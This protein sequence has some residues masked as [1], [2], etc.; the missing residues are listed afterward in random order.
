MM[1]KVNQS[2]E[3]LTVEKRK[4]NPLLDKIKEWQ[5]KAR[6]EEDPFNEY[7]SFFIAYNIFSNAAT[8]GISLAKFETSSSIVSSGG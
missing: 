1:G 4:Q 2:W 7:L 6:Q 8:L 5:E 3:V